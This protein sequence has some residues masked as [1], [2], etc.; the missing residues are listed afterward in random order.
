M[1]VVGPKLFG[2]GNGIIV[3]V[4]ALGDVGVSTL[5]GLRTNPGTYYRRAPW[6]DGG[7]QKTVCQELLLYFNRL[8]PSEDGPVGRRCRL[9][10]GLTVKVLEGQRDGRTALRCRAKAIYLRIIP[11]AGCLALER[12]DGGHGQERR[13]ARWGGCPPVRTR[14]D[15]V[16]FAI[17]ST[18]MEGLTVSLETEQLLAEW[19]EGT[20][21]DD[22]LMA[23]VLKETYT[24]VGRSGRQ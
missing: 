7:T 19:S 8:I 4:D 5:L 18:V 14:A 15:S 16:R 1:A 12:H 9:P 17:A 23:A 3:P 21:T 13:Y 2:L 10:T 22:E 6:T 11:I 24:A 20:L